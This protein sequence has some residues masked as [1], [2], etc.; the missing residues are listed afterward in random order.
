MKS[1]RNALT[2]AL[3][4][5]AGVSFIAMVVLT[6]WQVFTRY[7]LKNPSPWSE[8]LVSY[9]FAWASLLGASL[10]TGERGHMNIPIV[11][12]KFSPAVQKLL[13]IFGELVAFAFSAI[14]LV[15]GGVTITQ[16]AMGQMTSSLGVQ[17]GVF[18]VV[19]PLC[20]I[21]NMI[22]TV[23][24]IADICKGGTPDGKEA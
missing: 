5:L 16:L 1:L 20:G 4:V 21:L 10:V 17:V 19:M 9:L 3:N 13:N 7:V 24:N 14:I 18:Y 2:R 11:L 15:Y 23:L 12:E 8:E 6:C 22:Y